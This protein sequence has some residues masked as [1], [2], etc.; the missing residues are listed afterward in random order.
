[1]IPANEY[2]ILCG[3]SKM[4]SLN[5]FGSVVGFSSFNL[6][7]DEQSLTLTNE[8]DEIIDFIQY[9]NTWYQNSEKE[10]GG[11]SLEKIQ[12]DNICVTQ[13]NWKAS[14]NSSGG[15]PGK[16]NSVYSEE[17]ILPEI[18][19]VAIL[20]DSVISVS[21]NQK[22]KEESLF[23]LLN[24]SVD[25]AIGNP[26]IV[27]ISEDY[28]SI[29][30]LFENKFILG[31][32]YQLTLDADL[33]NC[34]GQNLEPPL[35]FFLV[36]N[37]TAE[38][39]DI[40]INEIMANPSPSQGSVDAEYLELYN[41]SI[42][43]IK[44]D[45]WSLIIGNSHFY[46][47][48][49][50][51]PAKSYLILTHPDNI[52]LFNDLDNIIAVPS[53]SLA[54]GGTNL[55]LKNNK[56]QIIHYIQYND[57]WYKDDF[58]SEGGWSLEMISTDY[59]CEQSMNW[60]A[61]ENPDGGTPGIENSIHNRY[62]NFQNPKIE[63]I[64]I[65]GQNVLLLQFSKSMDS[66]ALKNPTNY[67]VDNNFGLPMSITIF[68]P[69]YNL[70]Q[71]YFTKSFTENTIYEL[72]LNS[73]LIGCCGLEL[74][75][76]NKRFA[77]PQEAEEGD[78]IINEILFDAWQADGEYVELFNRSNKIIDT[79]KLLFSRIDLNL[80]DTSFYSF[81]PN[82]GQFFPKEYLL[83]CKNKNSVLDTYYSE[84]PD[85]I[86]EF[87]H[88]PLLPNTGGD[89]L[90]STTSNKYFIIDALHYSLEMHHHLLNNTH[91]VSLERLSPEIA[92][93]S[94]NNWMSA[95]ASVNHG[96]PAY[97]N[98]QFQINNN[99]EEEIQVTP[100][101]FSPDSD[102]FDDVLQ[103]NYAFS[104]SGYSLNLIIFNSQ[105][106]IINHLIKNE[107]MGMS[108]QVF[109]DGTSEEGDKAAIGIYI[110]YFEYFDLSG[111]VEKIKKTCVLGGKL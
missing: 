78:I 17:I 70:A 26:K 103:I 86:Y 97:Q 3:A 75:N 93:N 36:L 79:R 25:N 83:L 43:P 102:G 28:Q 31:I 10:S 99:S 109:W 50:S 85:A 35:S 47:S 20:N 30:L 91:G 18:L 8:S 15:T 12:A 19:N 16:I 38:Y 104:E 82:A 61:S 81:Q 94:I 89:I 71:L 111:R 74:E 105:G 90:L 60:S 77:L 23:N 59:F 5:S 65:E 24:Y 96:T 7:N 2:L 29:E 34:I 6:N 72:N 80:Y 48:E 84:N 4:D 46:F 69:E 58:K 53:F 51:F 68:P 41:Q 73:S 9:S 108:G 44:L 110:L 13:Q 64:D 37:K 21:F 98:S 76:L 57:N 14:T 87:A 1:V 40:L 27:V 95:A 88:F 106:Q 67:S 22:M 39:G 107:L 32:D 42:N 45:D 62:T 54:N 63:S 49:I 55:I 66:L 11:W 33:K 52:H 56:G 92:T 100:E 101:I